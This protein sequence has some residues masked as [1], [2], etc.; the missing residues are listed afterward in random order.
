MEILTDKDK[1][2]L[3]STVNS[4]VHTFKL[5]IKELHRR[6]NSGELNEAHFKSGRKALFKVIYH[7]HSLKNKLDCWEGYGQNKLLRKGDV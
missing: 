5:R 6:R 4:T 2:L 3:Q 7:L 1:Q